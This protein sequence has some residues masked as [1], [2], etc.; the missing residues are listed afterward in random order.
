MNSIMPVP[1]LMNAPKPR[2]AARRG[3][4][5][6]YLAIALMALLLVASLAVDYSQVQCA[7]TQ[8]QAATDAIA[9]YAATGLGDGTYYTKATT[10]AQDNSV[11]GAPL[12]LQSGDV[13]TGNWTSGT[14]TVGGSPKNCVKV[15]TTLSAARGTAVPVLFAPGVSSC[16]VTAT[17]YATY[18][19]GQAFGII[20]INSVELQ[21]GTITTDSWNSSLGAYSAGS[22]GTQGS[23][24]SNGDITLN[25]TVTIKTGVYLAPGSTVGGNGTL[26]YGNVN[27]LSADLSYPVASA[28]NASSSNNNSSLG[29]DYQSGNFNM[30]SGT[31]NVPAGTYYL[32]SFSM[33]G[34]TLNINGAATFYV[35]GNFT[36]QGGAVNVTG[37]VPSNFTVNVIA[38]AGGNLSSLSSL[39]IN[40]YCPTSPINVNNCTNLYGSFIGSTLSVSNSCAIHADQALLS[41]SG[42]SGGAIATVQ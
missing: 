37:N 27:T 5:V 19:A 4:A 41:G 7:K 8:L 11:D 12:A 25:G 13:V 3:F 18:S 20:G 21:N 10:V 33:S 6:L 17:S 24:A 22:A 26:S 36:I 15:S 23:V 29:S 1:N 31:V 39:Y 14:F 2:P 16:N 32:N 42:G 28:G 35:N 38:S 40:L 9:R 34:G 30:S